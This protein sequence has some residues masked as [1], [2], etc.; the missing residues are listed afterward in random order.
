MIT[1]ERLRRVKV[2]ITQLDYP[3][4]KKYCKLIVIHLN[5]KE[6]LDVDPKA[7]Q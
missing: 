4:F 3:C 2:M 7:I 1:L 5:N 6:K